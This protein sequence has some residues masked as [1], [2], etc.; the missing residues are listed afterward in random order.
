MA[1]RASKLLLITLCIA[2]GMSGH[3]LAANETALCAALA[4]KPP[5]W[6]QVLD[7]L[8]QGADAKAA[9]SNGFTPLYDAAAAGRDR[10]VRALLAR[11]ADVNVGTAANQLRWT[12]LIAALG[13]D[14]RHAEAVVK[15][16]VQHG[17][18][19]NLDAGN[20]L[21]PLASALNAAMVNYLVAHGAEVN[22]NTPLV[23]AASSGHT[24]AVRALLRH[25]ADINAKDGWGKGR[26]ALYMA[27]RGGYADTVCLLVRHG[28][29]VGALNDAGGHLAGVDPKVVAPCF[30]GLRGSS[31]L[32]KMAALLKRSPTDESLRRN[33]FVL[34]ATL[35]PRPR[36][37]K[38]AIDAEGRARYAF[39]H[40][41]SDEDILLAAKQ[42]LEA[43]DAAPWVANYYYDLGIV[44]AKSPFLRQSIDAFRLYLL[45]APDASDAQEVEEKRAGLKMALDEI[46]AAR[47][48][49]THSAGTR[50]FPAPTKE[51]RSPSNT[52]D[53]GVLL[54]YSARSSPPQYKLQVQCIVY[55]KTFLVNYALVSTDTAIKPCPDSQQYSRLAINPDGPGLVSLTSGS[56]QV[57]LSMTL[58]DLY[59]ARKQLMARSQVEATIDY[60]PHWHLRAPFYVAIPQNGSTTDTA[61]DAFYRTD[62]N[63]NPVNQDPHALPDHFLSY[64]E[65]QRNSQSKWAYDATPCRD[66]FGEQTDYRWLGAK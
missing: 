57:F 43:I 36:L 3:A 10:V 19:V 31:K 45:A 49:R 15:T 56:G 1:L 22:R 60:V 21:S 63:G 7:L 53:I 6:S 42:Y 37:P 33:I 52:A 58:D 44:L 54:V 30:N 23:D 12:P 26:T 14:K 65:A 41:K 35:N 47:R 11:G 59:Q 8:R 66:Q 50:S 48:Q 55:P 32:S 64:A 51:V 18:D 29:D 20:G 25:G 38:A 24:A 9:C 17:A 34:A 46:Q 16:L 2:A 61:G 28:A 4:A 13:N 27:A 5:E 39:G 62:C 40:A